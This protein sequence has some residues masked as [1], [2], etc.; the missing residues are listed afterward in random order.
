MT[1][2]TKFAR[3]NQESIA[4]LR[5]LTILHYCYW[6]Y[7]GLNSIAD[8]LNSVNLGVSRRQ[9]ERTIQALTDS[10]DF[11]KVSTNSGG[12]YYEWPDVISEDD[13]QGDELTD[14]WVSLAASDG[15]S[16]IV[17]GSASERKVEMKLCQKIKRIMLI[18]GLLPFHEAQDHGL[19]IKQ[20][21]TRLKQMDIFVSTR[22]LQ[23]DMQFIK[24]HFVVFDFPGRGR[25]SLWAK[26]ERNDWIAN[27]RPRFPRFVLEDPFAV[28]R[29]LYGP[30]GALSSK[31]EQPASWIR[32]VNRLRYGP[33][34]GVRSS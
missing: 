1:G 14:R 5:R 25:Q 15:R 6:N 13:A 11:R 9:L 26:D 31:S 28:A 27:F 12:I 2:N 30:H 33:T 16:S 8:Y 22:T 29:F 32:S 3:A 34:P 17:M 24:N 23:R 21:Q 19:S 7:G 18:V 10:F 4:V 20:I